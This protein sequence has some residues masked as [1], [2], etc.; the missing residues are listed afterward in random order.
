M[1]GP[2]KPGEPALGGLTYAVEGDM[3]TIYAEDASMGGQVPAPGPAVWKYRWSVYG[4]T[5][6]FEKQGGQEPGCSM[7]VSPAGC[8]PSVF[9]V[10]PWHRNG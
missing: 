9:V 1:T 4:D 5:L 8:Q 7:T 2:V 10:K 6:T 3:L